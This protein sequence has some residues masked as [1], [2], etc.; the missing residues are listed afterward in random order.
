MAK[1]SVNLD[2]QADARVFSFGTT[3]AGGDALVTIN[4]G[5]ALTSAVLLDIKG[6]ANI[7]GN[8]NLIGNL[9][10]T[11]AIS[12]QAVTNLAVAN[13]D[14][15]LNK[16]GTTA[17]SLGAGVYVEGDAG[18]VIAKFI[19]DSTLSSKWKVGDGVT[20]L[21]VVT[22]SG[23]QTLTN[24]LISGGQITSAVANATLA[25][26]VT[27]N[28]NLTGVITSSGNVTSI[29]AQTGT[30]ST[31]VVQTSPTL[32]T[33]VL[34]VATATSL[35]AASLLSVGVAST[36]NGDMAWYNSTTAFKQVFRATA[37]AADIIYLL[38]L[39]APTA[40]QVLQSTAPASGIATMSWASAAVGSVTSVSVVTANGVSGT[41]AT[42][43]STPA[44]TLVLGAITPTSVAATGTISGS[45]LTGTNTGDQT[46]VSGNSGSTTLTAITDDVATNATEYITWV[47][48]T[49]GNQAQRTSSTKLTFN[50]S[51]GTLSSTA[52]SGAGTGLTGTA[53]SL[54][55]GT[56]TTNANLTG[57][58]TSVGNVATVV[59]NANLTGDVISVGN[60]TTL[61]KYHR[62][63]V[64]TATQDGV[65]KIYTIGAAVMAGG[66]QVFSNGQL[67]N[68]GAT[69]D[70]VISGTTVT[71]QA[72]FSAPVATDTIR[73]YGTY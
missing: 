26:T 56:V 8:L 65:N 18:S 11:G 73:I 55:A 38:P 71:F 48:A 52:F 4:K 32:I 46:S 21:E 9:N 24:K 42:A 36:T 67:L 61:A 15:T 2:R 49:T 62:A 33:P 37:T 12:E 53:P 16:G 20:Q 3:S 64:V 44:I 27:T 60:A 23:V 70:Y 34:G 63:A 5:G 29:G 68:P 28:A 7:A 45:N 54:T 39:T 17:G 58:V 66:E 14:I 72:A 40:G 51:T 1:T 22:V 35:A 13:V 47:G 57:G 69:N 41:V 10:I 25:S 30:G 50:P 31:F 6:S 19:Y 59:T 43:S